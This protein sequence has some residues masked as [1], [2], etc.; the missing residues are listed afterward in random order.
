[1]ITHK[2]LLNQGK[3]SCQDHLVNVSDGSLTRVRRFHTAR[4]CVHRRTTLSSHHLGRGDAAA[5]SQLLKSLRHPPAASV[6]NNTSTPNLLAHYYTA[7]Q[8]RCSVL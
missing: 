3:A 7:C 1:M 6:A 5:L 4:S 2:M 8:L